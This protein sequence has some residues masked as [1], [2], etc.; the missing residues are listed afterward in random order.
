MRT[1]RRLPT[2]R[3]RLAGIYSSASVANAH[4]HRWAYAPNTSEW[5]GP[6]NVS[7][8]VFRDAKASASRN[9]HSQT[10]NVFRPKLANLAREARSRS[11]VQANFGSQYSGLAVG[12]LASLQPASWCQKHPCAKMASLHARSGATTNPLAV[13]HPGGIK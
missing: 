6:L 4:V 7:G 13:G 3:E 9:S 10:T 11:C 2:P 1:V 12:C 5:G 8:R